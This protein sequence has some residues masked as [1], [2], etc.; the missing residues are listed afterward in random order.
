M[1]NCKLGISFCQIWYKVGGRELFKVSK[2]T[3]KFICKVQATL[4]EFKGNNKENRENGLYS[5]QTSKIV[6]LPMVGFTIFQ[7]ASGECLQLLD[8][9]P[10]EF[11]KKFFNILQRSCKVL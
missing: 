7:N 2:Q 3:C 11:Y 5:F 6:K 9:I 10:D 8:L 4:M 1:G